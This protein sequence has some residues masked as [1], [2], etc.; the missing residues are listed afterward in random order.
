M[1]NI[2]NIIEITHPNTYETLRYHDLLKILDKQMKIKTNSLT[3]EQLNKRYQI[4]ESSI[5]VPQRTTPTKREIDNFTAPSTLNHKKMTLPNESPRKSQSQMNIPTTQTNL[6]IDGVSKL[7][8]TVINTE[9]FS[10]LE[11]A[12]LIFARQQDEPLNL[13]TYNR[14]W[15]TTLTLAWI[16]GKEDELILSDKNLGDLAALDPNSYTEHSVWLTDGK[17]THEAKLQQARIF[18]MS[19]VHIDERV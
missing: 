4:L 11:I 14:N 15:E 12:D 6:E 1:I 19:A 5:I 3:V 18:S 2:Q 10:V 9:E 16:Y 13:F 17:N 7:V 8:P